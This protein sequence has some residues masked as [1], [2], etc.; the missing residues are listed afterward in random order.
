MTVLK[1]PMTCPIIYPIKLMLIT[2]VD[3]SGVSKTDRQISIIESSIIDWCVR[4][5]TY[6]HTYSRT[7]ART[8]II[9]RYSTFIQTYIHTH[10]HADIYTY[11][12]T[13]TYIHTYIHRYTYIHIHTHIQTFII[14]I[15]SLICFPLREL[16]L[17]ICTA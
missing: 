6:I 10:I 16:I 7:Y 8:Y 17:L 4:A 11:I 1:A 9:H 5:C 12:H 2:L 3:R 15:L 13:H 14:F